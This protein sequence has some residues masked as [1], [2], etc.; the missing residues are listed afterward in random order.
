MKHVSYSQAFAFALAI[1]LILGPTLSAQGQSRSQ[2]K[3]KAFPSSPTNM[4]EQQIRGEG[5]FLQRC[6]LCHL[7]RE[8]KKSFGPDLKGVMKDGSPAR[9]RVVRLF[10]SSGVPDKMPGFQYGFSPAEFDDLIAYLKTLQ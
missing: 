4:T 2:D 1:S 6:Q 5:I 8:A 9:E 3:P 7:R 10:I